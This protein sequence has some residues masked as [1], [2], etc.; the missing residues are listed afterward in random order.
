MRRLSA[1]AAAAALMNVAIAAPPQ[2]QLD[3]TL[4]TLAKTKQTEAELKQRMAESARELDTIAQ[5]AATLGVRLQA[6]ERRVTSEESALEKVNAQV[7]QKRAE[8]EARKADYSKT[9]LS[10]LRLRS[11]PPTA[12][13]SAGDDTKTLLRTASLLEKTNAAVAQKAARLRGDIT[14]LK[15]LQTDAKLRDA[16]TRAEKASLRNEQLALERELVARQKLHARLNAD[17]DRAEADVAK[18]SRES[19]SLQELLG[20][21]EAKERAQQ[22]KA[23][24]ASTQASSK[25]RSFSAGKG[26][27][28]AP[29]AGEILHRF[30]DSQNAN[31]NYRGM[32]FKARPGATVV[33]PYD[34]V[35]VFTGPFRDYGNM[36]LIKHKNGYISLI[37]GLGKVNVGLNQPAIRGEPIGSMPE[38]GRAEAYVELRDTSAKPIDPTEWFA[39]VVGNSAS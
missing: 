19:Q 17:H 7:A 39:N 28:R 2:Q 11:L 20:K 34:G 33:A 32:V 18:L 10:L 25:L 4:D 29:V 8:F 9:V 5:R 1:F 35:V 3:T 14:S 16:S 21:L 23:K 26:S 36:V 38:D 15:K 24:L 30:G 12:V 13:I 22:D 37:A 31:G 27:A 6:S